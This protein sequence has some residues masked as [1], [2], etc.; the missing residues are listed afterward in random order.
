MNQP[1]LSPSQKRLPR[2]LLQI[3]SEFATLV[4][5]SSNTVR[6]RKVSSQRNLPCLIERGRMGHSCWV[7][8]HAVQSF[9]RDGVVLA[10]AG[11]GAFRAGYRCHC[12]Y[13]AQL[14]SAVAPCG[15]AGTAGRRRQ[16]RGKVPVL[17]SPW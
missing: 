15:T 9:H 14:L 4:R 13:S 1:L 11:G 10:R 12:T 16:E 5:R 8:D 6:C 17:C 7:S 3:P 2:K